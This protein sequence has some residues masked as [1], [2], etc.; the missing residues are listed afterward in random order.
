M[1]VV[2]PAIGAYAL[3]NDPVHIYWMLGFGV[4]G[5]FLKTDG[6]QVGR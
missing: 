6:F 4:A 1:I 3:K 5:Y 2:L